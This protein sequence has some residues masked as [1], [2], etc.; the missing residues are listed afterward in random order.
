MNF[1]TQYFSRFNALPLQIK[2][3]PD[4]NLN[5]IIVIPSFNEPNI[6]N[7]LISIS[8][9]KDFEGKV[10]V[11][12]V[13]NSSE[14]SPE[15]IKKRNQNTL[16]EI[17]NFIQENKSD[18][19][20]HTIYKPNLPEKTAGVGL[21]RKI[22]MD[23]AVRRF[24]ENNN[25]DGIIVNF[26]ADTLCQNNY[27]Q[28]IENQFKNNLKTN[29]CSIH[30]EHIIKGNKYEQEIYDAIILYELYLHYYIQALRFIKFP[31]AYHTIG[32]AFAVKANIYTKQGGMNTRK[33]G[34]DFYFLHKIIPL[35]NFYEIKNTTIFPSPRPSD[36]VPFGTGRAINIM[37]EKNDTKYL[38]YNLDSFLVLK[39]FFEQIKIL[40][41]QKNME[42]LDID[43]ILLDFLHKNNFETD[44]IK[45]KKN[46]PN[47]NIFKKRFFDWF[48][49]FR[50]LKFLNYSHENN[51]TK[52]AIIIE[53]KKLLDCLNYNN[54]D[55]N[56]NSKKL[57]KTYRELHLLGK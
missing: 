28:S 39:K 10:E 32:S 50:I 15:S 30:Y 35:G 5:I 40:F 16:I 27:I 25:P 3:K 7:S 20:F 12:I 48:N 9:N 57:L 47:I 37:L 49:A 53:S 19:K 54:L 34:E 44:L 36:R 8:N 31:Y 24:S 23:E 17:N 41:E 11:I 51:F 33:A 55:K 1:A 21:A 43:N 2:T 38:T 22:G 26:D 45:I 56:I 6:V 4:Q 29:A 46:S 52:K 18:I 42:K 13:V 14:N